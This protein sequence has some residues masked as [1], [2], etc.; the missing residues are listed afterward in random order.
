MDNI[1]E[2]V[3]LISGAIGFLLGCGVTVTVQKLRQGDNATFADQ[4]NSV[5]SGD[6]AGRDISKKK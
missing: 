1:K 2:Y 4:R 5:V 3:D 6:Q